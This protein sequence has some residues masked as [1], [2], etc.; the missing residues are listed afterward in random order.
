VT[1]RKSAWAARLVALAVMP[2]LTV[3]F[4]QDKKPEP[5]S[6]PAAAPVSPPGADAQRAGDLPQRASVAED[7]ARALLEQP[8]DLRGEGRPAGDRAL[9]VREDHVLGER[10]GD[11][12][13]AA[14]GIG[15]VE[16][17]LQHAFHELGD[18]RHGSGTYLVSIAP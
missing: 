7:E 11:G 9:G 6:A 3:A 5:P 14:L 4:A 2:L 13:V 18:G 17:V 10:R 12:S 8:G 1:H 16:H 15:L